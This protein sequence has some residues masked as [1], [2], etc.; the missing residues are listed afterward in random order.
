MFAQTK[1]VII[2]WA[3]LLLHSSPFCEGGDSHTQIHMWIL[4]CPKTDI[5]VP[6]GWRCKRYGHRTGDREC[7]FFIKG[8][9]KLEQ[10]RVVSVWSA[11]E[12]QAH[13]CL[14]S[15]QMIVWSWRAVCHVRIMSRI[16]GSDKFM[17]ATFCWHWKRSRPSLVYTE[18]SS[19]SLFHCE[20]NGTV[21]TAG[22]RSL[23]DHYHKRSC[24]ALSYLHRGFSKCWLQENQRSG[25]AGQSGDGALWRVWKLMQ[26]FVFSSRLTKTRCT[27]WSGRTNGMK[28]K[29]GT[30][31][32]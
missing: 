8:N 28:K 13:P 6:T 26:T 1:T 14:F 7:P 31:A 19:L 29:P 10:F 15:Y 17:S 2:F 20:Y 11:R 32:I 25:C 23:C 16:C 22:A 30:F 18:V 5:C 3:C 9:Q 12:V 27:T 21:T 24:V 4:R